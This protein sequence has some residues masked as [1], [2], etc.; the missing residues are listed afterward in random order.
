M[1][2]IKKNTGYMS[3]GLTNDKKVKHFLVH[4]L[5]GLSFIPNP[6]N[7]P[8]IDHINRITDDNRVINLRW[9][10]HK[11]NSQNMITNNEEMYIYK[12]YNK[13]CRQ[14]F[15]WSFQIYNNGKLKSIK[16]SVNKE[17]LIKYRD[18]WLNQNNYI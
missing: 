10:T 7:K 1:A 12:S 15:T 17:K 5:L 14:G 13:S 6:L 11:E 3:I 18:E 8:I 4:R 16:T 2:P 9:A